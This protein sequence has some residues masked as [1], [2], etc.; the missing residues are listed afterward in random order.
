MRTVTVTPGKGRRVRD[1]ATDRVL[2]E[3]EV[4]ERPHSAFWARR[5]RKGDVVEA[6]RRSARKARRPETASES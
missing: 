4:I 2:E 3:G 1:P 5:L 6:A